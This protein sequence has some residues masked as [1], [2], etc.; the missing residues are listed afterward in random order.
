MSNA[1]KS[2]AIQGGN[3]WP[4]FVSTLKDAGFKMAS[5]Y[6]D[7]QGIYFS[8]RT[9][10]HN[11]CVKDVNVRRAINSVFDRAQLLQSLSSGAGKVTG[12]YFPSTNPGY[13]SALDKKYPFDMA[14]AKEYMAKS[15]FAK[16]CEISMATFTPVFGE[17]VYAII[18]AQLGAIGIKVNETEETGGTFITNIS[19]PKYDAYLMIFE[20]SGNPWTLLNFMITENANFNNDHFATSAVTKLVADYKYAKDDKSRAAILKKINTELVNDAWFAPWYALQSNFAHKG[21]TVKSAQAGNVIPFLYN[22]K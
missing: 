21:I 12:Q 5:G 14:A 20:R 17:S 6:L 18:K 9:G 11:S 13:D 2:G 3:V 22:I 1:L 7:A 16:G 10:A 15:A 4:Q 8:D 19:A